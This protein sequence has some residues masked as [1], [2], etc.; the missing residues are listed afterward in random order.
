[1]EWKKAPMEEKAKR[2]IKKS[3]DKKSGHAGK[4]KFTI[5]LSEKDVL[6]LK[7]YLELGDAGRL[8]YTHKRERWLRE[9][10]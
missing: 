4:P 6:G 2:A 9:N 8:E 1:M 10:N 7:E 5:R 3:L